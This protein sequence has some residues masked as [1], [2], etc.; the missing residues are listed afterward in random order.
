MKYRLLN[1]VLIEWNDSYK[2]DS[3][4]EFIKGVD[5]KTS[6]SPYTI[7]CIYKE[8]KRGISLINFFCLRE[9]MRK[10]RI[11]G[12]IENK[13]NIYIN[14]E[15]IDFSEI[16][17]RGLLLTDKFK[18]SNIKREVIFEFNDPNIL[19]NLIGLFADCFFLERVEQFL[20][21]GK[22]RQKANKKYFPISLESDE[23]DRE[24]N[25]FNIFA[26]CRN[27]YSVCSIP[28]LLLQEGKQ[29]WRS[30]GSLR[31]GCG[32]IQQYNELAAEKK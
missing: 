21:F 13:M 25:C 17:S 19:T 9:N 29:I 2:E 32:F 18:D 10:Y 24:I 3:D 22:I 12:T 14:G 8:L 16:S 4:N 28:G 15:K 27:L 30:V 26:G 5:I 11:P 1:E 6:M 31:E 23:D 20:D 7:K